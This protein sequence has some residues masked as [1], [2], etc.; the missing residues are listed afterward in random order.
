ME[1]GTT[2]GS[3][4]VNVHGEWAEEIFYAT[5]AYNRIKLPI[6]LTTSKDGSGWCEVLE[7]RNVSL[8]EEPGILYRLDHDL[9]DVIVITNGTGARWIA[10][11]GGW[12]E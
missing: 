4:I 5:Y 3:G 11:W 8:N 10:K 9:Y 2:D 12:D 1:T 7:M 6:E